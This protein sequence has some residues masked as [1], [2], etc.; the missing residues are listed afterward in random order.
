[1]PPMFEN[2]RIV[3]VNPS[4]PGNIGAVA[5]AMKNMGFSKLYLVAPESFPHPQAIFRAVG[6][7]D[8]LASAV[9]TQ[10]L[11]TAL[12]GCHFVYATSARTRCVEWPVVD[13]RQC[14]QQIIN[15]Q[16]QQQIA[17]VFGRESSGLTNEELA[18]GNVRLNIPAVEDYSSLNLAAAV[19]ICVYEIRMAW[20]A[21]NATEVIPSRRLLATSEQ[22]SGFYSHL[23][24]ILIKIEFLNPRHP[25]KLMYRLKRLFSRSQMEQVEINILRGILTELGKML[26]SRFG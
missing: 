23:E 17:L 16:P 2:I 9:V 7:D 1:M 25:K 12:S 4:H 21:V 14:A 26:S 18:F 13:A 5:R 10:D 19:Q 8:V 15:Q 11:K 22:L 6:A 3:L 20:L 24:Q